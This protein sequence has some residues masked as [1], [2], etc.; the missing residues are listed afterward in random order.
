[1]KLKLSKKISNLVLKDEDFLFYINPYNNKKITLQKKLDTIACFIARKNRTDKIPIKISSDLQISSALTPKNEYKKKGVIFPRLNKIYPSLSTININNPRFKQKSKETLN[2]FPLSLKKSNS[3]YKINFFNDFEKSFYFDN[4]YSNLKYDASEI[5]KNKIE[6]DRLVMN[7]VNYLK[8][9]IFDNN[10]TK[11]EK[12]F[13]YGDDKKEIN[14]TLN[15]LTI[16]LE[17]MALPPEKQNKNL[18]LTLPIALLPLFYYKGIDTF[19]KLLVA[20]V[21]VENNFEKISFDEKAI[22]VALNNISDYKN[23][24]SIDNPFNSNKK[25]IKYEYLRSPALKRNLNFLNFN[26]FIFFWV[27]NT[28]TFSAKVTL[29]CIKLDIIENHISMKLFIDYELLFFL[30][31][32]KF[33]NWEFYIIKYLSTYSQYRTIFEQ[34]GSNKMIFNKTFFLKEPRTKINSFSEES[35]YNIYTDPYYNNQII[36]FNSFYINVSLIDESHSLENNYRI[37]FS[38]LQYL[39][40]YEIAKYSNKISL[41][42]KFLEIDSEKHTLN[43][44]FNDYD[45]FDVNLWMENMKTFS[46]SSLKNKININEELN[47]EFYMNNKKVKIEYKKPLWS[48]IKM[49]NKK[50]IV[51]SWEIGNEMEVNLIESIINPT[52][53]NKF[54]NL[55]L[56]KISQPIRQQHKIPTNI[57]KKKF[58]KLSIH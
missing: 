8:K 55:C 47:S 33:T 25:S 5:F 46:G 16:V 2:L 38:F 50:E 39:K 17:D 54:L 43:F 19:Q 26:Y 42:S 22:K 15:T 53:W 18:K 7:K 34:L 10:L 14:L 11:F 1:M 13:Y 23:I 30:Y 29:P 36:N 48:I 6:Y 52:S 49:E 40:L 45:E 24:Y 9:G 3:N 32:N 44:R 57:Q 37:I 35:L 28:R 20:I 27:T 56:E 58:S 51:K 21:K 31:K 4:E 12:T 41:L